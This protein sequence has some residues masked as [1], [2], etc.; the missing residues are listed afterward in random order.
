MWWAVFSGGALGLSQAPHCFAM[1]GP[2]AW[3]AQ[4]RREPT[5]QLA[6]YHAFRALGY[7]AVSFLLVGIMKLWTPLTSVLA[8]AAGGYLLVRALRPERPRRGSTVV[9]GG[10]PV[11]LA[12]SV[13]RTW[14]RQR[15]LALPRSLGCRDGERQLGFGCR[16]P[17]YP[18]LCRHHGPPPLGIC[19]ARSAPLAAPAL[20][21]SARDA[22]RHGPDGYLA[23]L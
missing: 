20:A 22:D 19:L 23:A 17:I 13:G 18:R 14:P 2:L 11:V 9:A 5:A 7:V 4:R 8:G 1:C 16:N 12:G 21:P 6:I 15:A 3:Q 10:Y